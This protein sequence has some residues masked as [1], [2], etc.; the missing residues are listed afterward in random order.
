MDTVPRDARYAVPQAAAGEARRHAFLPFRRERRADP[1]RAG[2]QGLVAEI[3]GVGGRLPVGLDRCAVA[4][5]CDAAGGD[6]GVKPAAAEVFDQA[7]ANASSFARSASMV[8][9]A[10][11]PTSGI[12]S[13]RSNIWLSGR[14]LGASDAAMPC[15]ASGES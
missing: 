15:R 4:E 6:G 1:H 9:L 7:R 12:A 8:G 11:S 5:P 2:G 3:Q 10:S 14:M 13:T